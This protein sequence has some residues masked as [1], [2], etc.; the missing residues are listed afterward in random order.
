MCFTS[1]S[2]LVVL[3]GPMKA[4]H[5]DAVCFSGKQGTGVVVIPIS[6]G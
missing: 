5:L 6:R 1:S 2:S 4:P 3:R